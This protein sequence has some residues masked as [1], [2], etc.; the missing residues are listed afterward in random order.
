MS[1]I[2]AIVSSSGRSNVGPK[3]TPKLDIVIKFLSDFAATLKY[4]KKE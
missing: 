1:I 2:A 4:Y 3:H